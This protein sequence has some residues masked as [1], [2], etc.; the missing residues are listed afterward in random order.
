[1]SVL[2][3]I[4][5]N[6]KAKVILTGEIKRVVFSIIGITIV[7]SVL[8]FLE[9]TNLPASFAIVY[10][11]VLVGLVHMISTLLGIDFGVEPFREPEKIKQTFIDK[12]FDNAIF[13]M[14]FWGIDGIIIGGFTGN[15][16][17]GNIGAIIGGIIGFGVVCMLVIIE[18]RENRN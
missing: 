4:S 16:V 1:M 13:Q 15:Y 11:L 7:L 14:I 17:G 2:S 18:N 3:N 5:G 9:W 10:F 8:P 6:S 12:I